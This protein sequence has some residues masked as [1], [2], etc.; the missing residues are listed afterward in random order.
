MLIPLG[1]LASAGGASAAYEL[2]S[3]TVLGSNTASVTFT[4]GGSWSNY[5]HLQIRMTARSISAVTEVAAQIRLNSDTGANY[6]FHYLLGGGSTP[7]AGA[8]TSS[9][10]ISFYGMAGGSATA[11]SFGV[12]IIDILDYA[13][14]S[15]NKTLRALTGVGA[16]KIGLG[17]GV[18]LNT[19]AVSS[20][21]IYP[22]GTTSWATGSRFSIYGVRG[23]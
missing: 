15:K 7:F 4:D 20:V 5:K 17:S 22:E 11:N 8:S 9:T 2:I 14:T 16:T 18:W 3:T 13:S 23:S 21:L 10:N 19:A 6:A 1:I 12:G